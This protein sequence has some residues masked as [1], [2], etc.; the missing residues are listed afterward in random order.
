MNFEYNWEELLVELGIIM[1]TI[2]WKYIVST[3]AWDYG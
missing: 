3:F 1:G 2:M